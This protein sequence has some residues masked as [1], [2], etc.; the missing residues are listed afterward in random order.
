M[1]A[2]SRAIVSLGSNIE[3]RRKYLERAVD[4]LSRL[5]E[6]NLVKTSSVIETEPVDVPPEFADLKF[7]NQVA[8]FQT[9]LSPHDFSVR[10]HAIEDAL[11][12][13]RTVKNAPRT[14]DI[15]LVDFGGIRLSTPELTLPHPRAKERDFVIGPLKELGLE[16]ERPEILLAEDE[17]VFRKHLTDTLEANGYSVRAVSNGEKALELYRTRKPDLLLLDIMMPRLNGYDVCERI[18]QTDAVTPVLFLTALDSDGDEVKGLSAGADGY[19]VKTVSEDVLLARI[20]A[21]MRRHCQEEPSGR[22]DF[23]GWHVEPNRLAMRY[24]R[25]GSDVGLSEREVAL[26]RLFAFRSGEL[27]S[28]ESLL[29]KFWGADFAGDENTLTVAISRLKVKLGDVGR[30]LVTIRGSGYVFRPDI[31]KGE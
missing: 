9:N 20:A 2:V 16:L 8:V 21:V 29:A 26:L 17:R 14:I 3:P 12:R 15:D 19:I 6:T 4:E 13:V 5:P 10:M 18:R 24:G 11:G 22:F 1:N 25:D 31:L 28:R 30:C 7:L 23:A 27:C